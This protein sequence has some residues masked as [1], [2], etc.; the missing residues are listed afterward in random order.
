MTTSTSGISMIPALRNCSTSPEPGCTT[1]ATVSATSATSVSDWP[2]PTVSITTTSKAAASAWAAARVAGARP[3]SRS[4]AAVERMKTPRSSGSKAIRARSPSSAPPL[5]LD[6][7]ST[8]STAT[9]RPPARHARHSALNKRRLA[10]ARRPGDADDVP[11]RLAAQPRRRDLG[12]SARDRLAVA[13]RAALDEVEDG[14]RRAQVAVAQPRAEGL[15]VG[16]QR[17]RPRRRRRAS[18]RRAPR[19]RP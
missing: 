9:V 8:A 17:A 5:R 12:S 1:T 16:G 3:P 2:T 18:R 4:P 11:A 14:G 6:D 19:C 15:A 10:R 7:G 13:R